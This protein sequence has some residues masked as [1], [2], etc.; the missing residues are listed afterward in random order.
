MVKVTSILAV[1]YQAKGKTKGLLEEA[2][3]GGH[4]E[5]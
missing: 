4:L 2:G 3:R 1:N 5:Q